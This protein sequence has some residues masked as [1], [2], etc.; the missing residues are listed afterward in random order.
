MRKRSHFDRVYR[1]GDRWSSDY[2]IYHIIDKEDGPARIGLVTPNS[3]GSA[4]VRNRVKRVVREAFRKDK[5]KFGSCDFIVRPKEKASTLTND[6]LRK[7]FLAGFERAQEKA[8]G[9]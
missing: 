5:K 6:E 4:V 9:S 7:E 8:E 2:I 3:L 1:K